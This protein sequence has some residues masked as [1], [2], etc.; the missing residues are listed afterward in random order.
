MSIEYLGEKK[1][2]GGTTLRLKTWISDTISPGQIMYG[3]KLTD[4]PGTIN[5]PTNLEDCADPRIKDMYAAIRSEEDFQ[6]I[7]KECKNPGC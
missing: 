6:R 2:E 7:T 5:F 3:L 1:L 4:G